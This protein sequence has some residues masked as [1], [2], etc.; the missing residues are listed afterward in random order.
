MTVFVAWTSTPIPSALAGPWEEIRPASAS[1]SLISSGES[2]SRVYHE[3]KWA[4]PEDSALLV[5]P[6]AEVPKLRGMP[7]GTLT[8]L[9]DRFG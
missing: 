7:A 5:A 2:L 6:V 3:L 8:W 1:L 4:L 9:R